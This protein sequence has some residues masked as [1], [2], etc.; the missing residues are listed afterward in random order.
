MAR[1][2]MHPT[3]EIQ[4]S[5]CGH[6]ETGHYVESACALAGISRQ[7]FYRWMKRG[8]DIGDK[9]YD[10]FYEAVEKATAKAEDR[11]LKFII[12]ASRDNWQANA[13][14]LERRHPAR[15]GRKPVEVSHTGQVDV[16]VTTQSLDSLA[17]EFHELLAGGQNIVEGEIILETIAGREN[18]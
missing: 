18:E 15:W 12:V 4:Q 1:P 17:R 8:R 6:L 10:V 5:I 11:A 14:Y 16:S 7:T 2:R 9:P 3:H 13:W